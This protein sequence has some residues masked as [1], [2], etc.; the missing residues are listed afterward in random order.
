MLTLYAT[1]IVFCCCAGFVMQTHDAHS[2]HGELNWECAYFM[3]PALITLALVPEL[4]R[5]FKGRLARLASPILLL[6]A[7]ISILMEQSMTRSMEHAFV[8]PSAVVVIILIIQKAHR[9]RLFPW[10]VKELPTSNSG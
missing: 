6:A 1:I 3:T 4:G 8:V 10:Q 9:K 2:V 5:A 7:L